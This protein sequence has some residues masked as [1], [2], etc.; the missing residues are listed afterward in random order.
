MMMTDQ[1][2]SEQVRVFFGGSD[3]IFSLSPESF[4]HFLKYSPYYY[5]CIFPP[6]YK[7]WE[8]S[9]RNDHN[10]DNRQEQQQRS[11]PRQTKLTRKTNEIDDH[12]KDQSEKLRNLQHARTHKERE[13]SRERKELL[14]QKKKKKKEKYLK[15]N[16]ERRR[17]T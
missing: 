3:G 17:K 5:I 13:R 9:F 8:S 15:K 2:T 14:I 16:T 12:D 11:T 10:N 1:M 7:M 6:F 4:F